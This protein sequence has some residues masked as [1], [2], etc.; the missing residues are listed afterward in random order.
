VRRRGRA[1]PPSNPRMQPTDRTCPELGSGAA[2]LEDVGE[3]NLVRRLESRQL[4]R[5]SLGRTCFSPEIPCDAEV[6]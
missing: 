6:S 5:L 4:L 2:S 1:G 3:R